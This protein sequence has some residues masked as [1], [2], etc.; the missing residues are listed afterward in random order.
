MVFQNYLFPKISMFRITNCI[1]QMRTFFGTLNV[2][3]NDREKCK[4]KLST[5]KL[6]HISSRAFPFKS[7]SR[8]T[9]CCGNFG[10]GE[11]QLLPFS[12][13]SLFHLIILSSSILL[14]TNFPGFTTKVAEVIFM[15]IT[16]LIH[17]PGKLELYFWHLVLSQMKVQDSSKLNSANTNPCNINSTT[18]TNYTITFFKVR[19]KFLSLPPYLWEISVEMKT[20]ICSG[21]P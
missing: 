15:L 18:Q 16:Q 17:L 10:N 1:K 6:L 8:E 2:Y 12:N 20:E 21:L 11:N 7:S 9:K 5:T 14:Q 3:K 4:W 19:E 13:E